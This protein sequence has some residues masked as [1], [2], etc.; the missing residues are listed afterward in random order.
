M[1]VSPFGKPQSPAHGIEVSQSHSRDWSAVAVS[2]LGLVGIDIE[3]SRPLANCRQL[4]CQI[5]T[6]Q[7]ARLFEDTPCEFT[8]RKLLELWTR[9]E[10]LLKCVGL[11]LHQDPRGL[12]TGWDE[13]AVKFDDV[14]YY[15]YPLPVCGQLIGHLS[16]HALHKRSSCVACHHS[17]MTG[18]PC[19]SRAPSPT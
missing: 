12:H 19:C 6:D 11:G 13:P 1:T 10:A 5:M 14:Q 15:L 8:V 16:S 18:C 4:A 2:A 9:K 7:E 3:H 17:W